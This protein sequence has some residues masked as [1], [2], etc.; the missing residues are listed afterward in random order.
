MAGLSRRWLPVGLWAAAATGQAPALHVYELPAAAACAVGVLWDHGSGPG[1]AEVAPVRA[2]LA[3]CRLAAARRLAPSMQ[4]Q[5]HL[6]PELLGIVG[7]VPA[8]AAGELPGFLRALL[9]PADGATDD[10]LALA[11]AHAALRVDDQHEVLPGGVLLRRARTALWPDRPPWSGDS[12][13]IAAVGPRRV[14][15]LLAMPTRCVVAA[16]GALPAELRPVLASLVPVDPPGAAR[17]WRREGSPALAPA[18]LVDAE[19]AFVDQPFVVA[20]FA[21]PPGGDEVALA[22]A[23]A[24]VQ[25]R[26]AQRWQLR[27][28]ELRARAPFVVHEWLAGDDL[29]AF[30]RRGVDFVPLLPGERAADAAAERDA[31]RREILELILELRAT[32]LAAAE[33]ERA[34]SVRR[35]EIALAAG[36]AADPSVLAAR[37]LAAMLAA[38]RGFTADGIDAVTPAAAQQALAQLLAAE[39]AWHSVSPRPVP[40]R[41]FRSR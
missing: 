28:T 15:E 3:Q 1:A 14:R 29:V 8:A 26:A 40:G 19:H 34:R 36:P 20:A 21:V 24:A 7:V 12:P 41:G 35:T 38:E 33:V 25:L 16:A 37:L 10:D 39:P 23:T 2:A 11:V 4:V 18:G 32:P 5:V 27:G 9:H 31:T 17:R 6:D 13:A 22:V 30:L